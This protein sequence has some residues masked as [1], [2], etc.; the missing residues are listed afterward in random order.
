MATKTLWRLH[1]VMARTGLPKS[2][3]YHL[4]KLERFPQSVDIGLRS[5]ARIA[6]EVEE[7][8]QDRIDASR[9]S[10]QVS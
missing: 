7:W 6:D 9:D 5:V 2:T 8:I 10:G 4:K 3:I 1:T